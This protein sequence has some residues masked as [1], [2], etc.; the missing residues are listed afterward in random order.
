MADWIAPQDGVFFLLETATT[1]YHMGALLL[2]D[3]PAPPRARIAETIERRL[4]HL[5]R[6]RA[7]IGTAPITRR[8]A[9]VNDLDFDIDAH[10]LGTRAEPP[11]TMRELRD[12]TACLMARH[13]DRRRPLWEAWVIEGLAGHRTAVLL[14]VHHALVDG[15]RGTNDL[16]LLFDPAEGRPDAPM[17]SPS[18]PGNLLAESVIDRLS[19]PIAAMRALSHAAADPWR[20]GPAVAAAALGLGST[21]ESLIVPAPH[22]PFNSPIGIERIVDHADTSLDDIKLIRKQGGGTVNDVV[23]AVVAGALRRWMIERHD[24]IGDDPF[25][26][27]VPMSLRS[28]DISSGNFVTGMLAPLPVHQPDPMLRLEAVCAATHTDGARRQAAGNAVVLQ[29]PAFLPRAVSQAIAG[30]Q[31]NQRYFNIS[32]PNIRGPEQHLHLAGSRIS[33]IVPLPPLSANA[34]LIVCAMSYA[35]RMTFGLLADP[36]IVPDLELIAEGIEKETGLLLE[37]SSG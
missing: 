11:G 7:R 17:A 34:G 4:R 13:L 36:D 24:P 1:P 21:L 5:P 12:T 30:I 9:W 25:R 29:L 2:L 22:S 31:R 8:R 18:R 32:L 27:L 26:A 19:S 16:M 14:K 23:L 35:G 20:I 33:T 3:D 37:R 28:G 10:V 6:F 15:V